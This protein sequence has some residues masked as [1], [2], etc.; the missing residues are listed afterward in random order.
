MDIAT[1]AS[2]LILI[3][4]T[5]GHKSNHSIV[6]GTLDSNSLSW[7]DLAFST[8]NF[9][10]I[11]VFEFPGFNKE[12]LNVGLSQENLIIGLLAGSTVGV[13]FVGVFVVFLLL[14]KSK[15]EPVFC[16]LLVTTVFFSACELFQAMIHLISPVVCVV[17]LFVIFGVCTVFSC[18]GLSIFTFGSVILNVNNIHI[19][20]RIKSNIIKALIATTC[21]PNIQSNNLIIGHEI[22]HPHSGYEVLL[23][24][25]IG[26]F[27]TEDTITNNA[28]D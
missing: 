15:I 6:T 7:S 12:V 20:I 23:P 28:N 1:H 13:I 9:S 10:L 21:H 16:G 22:Y 24:S 3:W 5:D 27:N 18:A 4:T 17:G 11:E 14:I 26:K 8:K 19:T 25:M 2:G